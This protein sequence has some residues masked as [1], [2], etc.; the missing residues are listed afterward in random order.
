MKTVGKKGVLA[1]RTKDQTAIYKALEKEGVENE[2]QR[3]AAAIPNDEMFA[4]NVGKGTNVRAVREK[5]AADRFKRAEIGP[6][7]TAEFD[8]IRKLMR[9][10]HTQPKVAPK[11]PDELVDLW[12]T[13]LDI[14][15][16][17]KEF[18]DFTKGAMPKIKALMTPHAGQSFNPSSKDHKQVLQKVL[19]EEVAEIEKNLKNSIK[20]QTYEANAEKIHEEPGAAL[21]ESSSDSETDEDFEGDKAVNKAV[22][23]D[24][25][26]TKTDRNKKVSLLALKHSAHCES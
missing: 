2:R 7:S 3:K 1:K 9:A 18:K 26:K 24:K 5:L 16:R 15:K 13:P 14:S 20:H 21:V 17:A 22:T 8:K 23:R 4:F 19:N 11:N 10:P 25:A 12:A 6:H